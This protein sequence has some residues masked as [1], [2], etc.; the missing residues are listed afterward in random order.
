MTLATMSY[1]E[2][3]SVT[4]AQ[5]I[6]AYNTIANG[7]VYVAPHLAKAVI[8][9]HGHERPLP[10]PAS[11]RVVSTTVA[12]QMT[13]ILEQV[14]A[15]GT[16]TSAKVPPY[17]VA[18][19]TGTAQY[20]G[21]HGYVTGYTDASFAGFAPAQKPAVTVLVTVEDTPDYGA[22]AAAPAFSTITR[23]ALTDLRIPAAGSQPAAERTA[24][25]QPVTA[26]AV[27]NRYPSG[28]SHPRATG[29]LVVAVSP[30]PAGRPA[31]A[32]ETHP[33]ALTGASTR[34]QHASPRRRGPP[35]VPP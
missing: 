2:G 13:S 33:A 32:S 25:P 24:S 19:K 3:I 20:D 7:G 34:P 1:G 31:D 28:L 26:G 21:P 15:A 10:R 18:G 23:D 11:H 9:P 4:A 30:D 29:Q 14:V 27:T 35:A 16:G 8:G 5:M 12:H 22:Q 6:T 17:A